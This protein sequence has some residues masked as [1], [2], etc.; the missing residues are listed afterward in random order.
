MA[1]CTADIFA[2]NGLIFAA[3]SF[4]FSFVYVAEES[5]YLYLRSRREVRESLK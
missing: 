2:K 4:S 5:T 1:S 3:R